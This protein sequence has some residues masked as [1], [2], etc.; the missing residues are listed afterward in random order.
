MAQIT[1]TV[2]NEGINISNLTNQS[3]GD[4]A[5]TILDVDQLVSDKAIEHIAQV[6]NIIKVRVIK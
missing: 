1:G 6:E 4:Y 2:G 5:V 3:K